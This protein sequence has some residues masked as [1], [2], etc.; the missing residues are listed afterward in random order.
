MCR[1]KFLYDHRSSRINLRWFYT[2]VQG[3]LL[4]D[5]LPAALLDGKVE[6]LSRKVPFLF[7][8][9]LRSASERNAS[10]QASSSTLGPDAADSTPEKSP[11][12][13]N[14]TTP[15]P[16]KAAKAKWEHEEIQLMVELKASGLRHSDIAVSL[17]P[18]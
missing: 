7:Q 10:P 1:D 6:R 15:V 11:S 17:L 8:E 14:D 4:I 5:L 12:S 3:L 13:S 18:V 9:N 2:C 16:A